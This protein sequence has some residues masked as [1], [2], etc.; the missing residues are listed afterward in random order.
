MGAI[1]EEILAAA[2]ARHWEPSRKSEGMGGREVAE[3]GA[4][5][6][7]PSYSGTYIGDTWICE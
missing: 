1:L 2:R 3:S 7:G 5:R 6:D 4:G